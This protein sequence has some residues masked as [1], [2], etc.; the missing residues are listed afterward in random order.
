M[1]HLLVNLIAFPK[2]TKL[3]DSHQEIE[4]MY[5]AFNRCTVTRPSCPE[6]KCEIP[7]AIMAEMMPLSRAQTVVIYCQGNNGMVNDRKTYRRLM[8]LMAQFK[9][10]VVTFDYPGR[11]KYAHTHGITD[12]TNPQ[13]TGFT[14]RAI[15]SLAFLS[16]QDVLPDEE[17]VVA[18]ARAVCSKILSEYPNILNVIVWG[19]SLGSV[20]SCSLVSWLGMTH[21]TKCKGHV[22]ES[23]IASA[24][25]CAFDNTQ[26][27]TVANRDEL[28][29]RMT[30]MN[31]GIWPC[32]VL[33]FHG[34]HDTVISIHNSVLLEQ[35]FKQHPLARVKFV[36]LKGKDHD[37]ILICD[38]NSEVEQWFKEMVVLETRLLA[39]SSSSIGAVAS[40]YFNRLKNTTSL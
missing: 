36:V 23:G 2:Q 9:C 22:I 8:H 35:T 24:L 21:P 15:R 33:L 34:D 31:H 4:R 26:C 28:D 40:S 27:L 13:V 10:P 19:K 38:L 32:P 17:W 14:E 29:N 11:G 12:Q 5:T 16:S 20:A 6:I 18:S 39:P 1:L 25:H 3:D 37:D 30:I 7:I